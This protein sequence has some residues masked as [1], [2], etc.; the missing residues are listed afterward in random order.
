MTMQPEIIFIPTNSLIHIEGFSKKR[1]DWLVEKIIKENFWTKPL[2]VDLEH[3][4]VL[5]GQHRM[6]AAKFLGLTNVPVIKYDYSKVKLWSLRPKYEFDWK[7][8][9]RR[10]LEGMPYPYKTVK[11]EFEIKLPKCEIPLELLK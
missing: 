6:E 4:L 9:T 5:D 1:V 2:A 11:H 8:V 3:H 7:E 10:S